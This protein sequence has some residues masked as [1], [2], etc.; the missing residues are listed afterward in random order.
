MA[1]ARQSL[2]NISGLLSGCIIFLSFVA[3]YLYFFFYLLPVL[4]LL[5][6][7]PFFV[8]IEALLGFL[9]GLSAINLPK[10]ILHLFVFLCDGCLISF[11]I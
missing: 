7:P 1:A 8:F 2:H 6:P 9:M 10:V 11:D 3:C 5:F 4:F